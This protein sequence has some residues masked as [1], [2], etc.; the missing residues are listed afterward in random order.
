MVVF[1]TALG[2]TYLVLGHSTKRHKSDHTQVGHDKSD[3]GWKDPSDLTIYVEQ[4]EGLHFL[5]ASERKVM[6]LRKDGLFLITQDGEITSKG[7]PIEYS[8]KPKIGLLPIELSGLKEHSWGL[9]FG[10]NGKYHVGNKIT[11][12]YEEEE[13]ENQFIG[14]LDRLANEEQSA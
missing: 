2:S 8:L 11:E 1:N 10:D 7:E 4:K 5:T 3:I 14:Y 12:I 13:E 6:V 9:I